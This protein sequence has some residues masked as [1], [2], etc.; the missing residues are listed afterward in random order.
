MD[1]AVEL[2]EMLKVMNVTQDADLDWARQKLEEALMGVT[3][4]DLKKSDGLRKDVKSRV[5]ELADK[6]GW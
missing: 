5:D 1:N 3:T 2:C 4:E 6:L